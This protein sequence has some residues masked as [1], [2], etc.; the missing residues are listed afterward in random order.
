MILTG[1]AQFK[2]EMLTYLTEV[3]VD[4]NNLLRNEPAV[5]T[6]SLDGHDL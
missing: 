2:F 1:R 3:G 6:E 5:M 4:H